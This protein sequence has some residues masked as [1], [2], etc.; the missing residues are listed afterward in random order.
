MWAILKGSHLTVEYD[1]EIVYEDDDI[2][3]FEKFGESVLIIQRATHITLLTPFCV[4][5][6]QNTIYWKVYQNHLFIVRNTKDL[7]TCAIYNRELE[8]VGSWQ[9][10][11]DMW[12][13]VYSRIKSWFAP[14][15]I[16][17]WSKDYTTGVV[18]NMPHKIT[19]DAPTTT[20]KIKEKQLLYNL[21]EIFEEEFKGL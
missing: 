8:Q 6:V 7:I 2:E 18:K 21:D 19:I 11:G 20:I 1:G 5:D 17:G 16:T 15:L 14:F 4:L 12:C 9:Y 13:L 3:T 10:I